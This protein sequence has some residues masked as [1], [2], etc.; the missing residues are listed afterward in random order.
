LDKIWDGSA[1]EKFKENIKLQKGNQKVCDNPDLLLEKDLIQVK[2]KAKDAGFINEMDTLAIGEAVCEIG[3]GRVKKE[4]SIDNAVGY[5][6]EKKL[7]DEVKNHETLGV[8][9]CRSESQAAKVLAKLQ[10]AY[11]INQEK[12]IRKFELI[13][14]VIS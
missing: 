4:D 7:G 10:M 6:C 14:E 8:L 3:G 12:T 1:L 2:V 5:I 9:L 11:K 13:K